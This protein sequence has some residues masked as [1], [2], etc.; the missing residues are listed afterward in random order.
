VI[1]TNRFLRQLPILACVLLAAAVTACDDSPTAPAPPFSQIDL[2]AGS[3]TAAANGNTLTVF[4]TGWLHDNS[5]PD[6]KGLQFET[7]VGGT[8]FP[9]TLGAGQVI[10]GWDLGLQ[11]IQPGGVRRLVIPPELAYGTVRHGPIPPNATLIFEVEVTDV[12]VVQ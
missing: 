3:G 9:F 12:T 10:A 11:G 6:R 2:R 5:K 4:Y 7:N 8:A 1:C